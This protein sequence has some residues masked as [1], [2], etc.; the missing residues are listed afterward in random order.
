MRVVR[1][2]AETPAEDRDAVRALAA[3]VAETGESA[4]RV[5]T[6]RRHLA[7]GRRDARAEGYEAARAAAERRGFPPLERDVGG[8]AVAYTGTTL[9]FV[10]VDPVG[11]PRRGMAGRYDRALVALSDA[12]A[13]LG[14]ET[15][16]GEPARAFC[17]GAHSLSAA[18]GGKLVGLA[19]RV[20]KSAARVGGVLVVDG[21]EDA[22]EVLAPVYEAL[23]VP[24]D[25]GSVGSVERALDEQVDHER[26]RRSVERAL[27]GETDATVEYLG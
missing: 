21:R 26:V 1:G 6:P 11:D 25:P 18:G 4:V 5:W 2:R 22:A 8:R 15:R 12:L 7:F 16:E 17:P 10:R 23:D 27:V 24:F 20:G 9:A 19:Q 13:D 14:V 3:D